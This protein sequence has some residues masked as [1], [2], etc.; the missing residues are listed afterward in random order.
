MPDEP[1]NVTKLPVNFRKPPEENRTLLLPWEVGKPK[2]CYHEAFVVDQEKSEVECA[3][4][5]EKLN[6]MW[7]LSYLAGQDRRMAE[8]HAYAQESMS[9]LADRSRTKC[10]HCGKMTRIRGI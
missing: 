3:K 8:N 4:C 1:Q 5:G 7:V 10:Q 6:P 9:R 2:P